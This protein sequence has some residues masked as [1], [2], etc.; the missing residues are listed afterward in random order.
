[1]K[2]NFLQ[3]TFKVMCCFV[4]SLSACHFYMYYTC[5]N[6]LFRL[7]SSMGATTDPVLLTVR[8]KNQSVRQY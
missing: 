3:E 2:H 6:I 7:L 5:I 1:M 8:F 4:W